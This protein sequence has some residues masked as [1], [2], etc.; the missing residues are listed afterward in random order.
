M[1]NTFEAAPK[2]LVGELR[3][4]LKTVT[5]ML[6]PFPRKPSHPTFKYISLDTNKIANESWTGVKNIK[7]TQMR[8]KFEK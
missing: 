8:E 3:E 2:A 5:C 1:S 7:Q 4:L 6:T